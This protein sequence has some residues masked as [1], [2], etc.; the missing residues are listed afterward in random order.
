[1]AP[2]SLANAKLIRST[3]A[4]AVKSLGSRQLFEINLLV[5]I[6]INR[7]YAGE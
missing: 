1:M 2:I 7:A 5:G 4:R 6:A 3:F